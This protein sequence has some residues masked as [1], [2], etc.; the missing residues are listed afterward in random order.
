MRR[1]DYEM[2]EREEMERLLATVD[3]GVLGILTP[4]GWP[5]AVP[6]NFVF[7]D[8]RIYF[9]G[10]GEGEKMAAIEH[11]A[12]ATFTVA[13]GYAIVPSYFRDPRLACPATQYY[14]C[15]MVRGRARVVSDVDE[16][17]RALQAM[18]DKLQPEGGFE[19]IEAGN[20]IY[21]KSL[22]TTAV[23]ALEI[24]RMTGKFKFG[25][26]LPKGKRNEVAEQLEARGCPI[27]HATVDAMRRYND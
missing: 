2:A 16:K 20:P 23:V 9:H 24:E 14:K 13:E 7:A 18:M 6:L 17:A 4:D 10:A 27:D 5:S 11:D 26:N 21:R 12:R 25:Q 19:P 1:T 22:K 15:V 8:G 3:Y